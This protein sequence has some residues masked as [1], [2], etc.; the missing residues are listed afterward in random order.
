MQMD[1]DREGLFMFFK[2]YQIEAIKY[3]WEIS[4]MAGSR[5]VWINVNE[6][7]SGSISKA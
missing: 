4:P 3:L 2:D 5:D 7:I 6:K 1:T